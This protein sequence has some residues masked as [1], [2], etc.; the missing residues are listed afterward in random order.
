MADLGHAIVS[1]ERIL[2]EYD[3][4]HASE[5]AKMLPAL[6][7]ARLLA[8]SVN[9]VARLKEGYQYRHSSTPRPHVWLEIDRDYV[10]DPFRNLGPVVEKRW[11]E[12]MPRPVDMC[13]ALTEAPNLAPLLAHLSI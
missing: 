2:T 13:A 3:F 10:F 4:D 5:D 7:M 12:T 1:I 11:P 9:H 6:I 8:H